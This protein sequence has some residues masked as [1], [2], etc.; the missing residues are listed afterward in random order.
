MLFAWLRHESAT[1]QR[2]AFAS[3]PWSQQVIARLYA[4]LLADLKQRLGY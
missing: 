3:A 4:P 2:C 1:Q